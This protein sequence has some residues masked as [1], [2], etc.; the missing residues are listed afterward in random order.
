MTEVCI[1]RDCHDVVII[2][3]PKIFHLGKEPSRVYIVLLHRDNVT[4][5]HSTALFEV[6]RNAYCVVHPLQGP[7]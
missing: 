3:R 2:K 4:G 6:Q 7:V 5:I 1:C